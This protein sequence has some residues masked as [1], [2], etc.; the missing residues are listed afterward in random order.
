[1]LLGTALGCCVAFKSASQEAN[2]PPSQPLSDLRAECL[3]Q[4][5][6][7]VYAP[8]HDKVPYLS[9]S[10]EGMIFLTLKPSAKERAAI[11]AFL[12]VAMDCEER[13]LALREPGQAPI[14]YLYE[15]S[16]SPIIGGL[17]LL[18][19]GQITYSEYAMIVDMKAQEPAAIA[20]LKAQREAQ[21]QAIITLSCVF[22]GNPTAFGLSLNGLEVQYTID[23]SR[24]TATASRGPGQPT[25]V[26]ISPTRISFYQGN[27][28]TTISRATGR[29]DQVAKDQPV[30]FQGTCEPVHGAKF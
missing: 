29:F 24:K 3:R 7:P 9:R 14:M 30:D 15:A 25:D 21:Q 1:M 5:A 23:T 11:R 8:I 22:Q 17:A 26:E 28:Y 19:A 18:A 4:F 2:Q 16:E 12:P 20:Q 10:T 27:M 6:Q 13:S